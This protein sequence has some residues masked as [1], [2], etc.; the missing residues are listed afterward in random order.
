MTQQFSDK[1]T[2]ESDLFTFDFSSV[3]GATETI[4]TATCTVALMDGVDASPSSI[5]SG[6]ATISGTQATQRIINGVDTCTYRLIMTITTSL[7]NTFVGT[8]D[9]TVIAPG[10]FK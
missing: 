4:S 3:L 2:T 10:D 9:V 7:S 6:A 1:F 5:L 8:G